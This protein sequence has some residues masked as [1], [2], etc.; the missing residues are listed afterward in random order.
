MSDSYE[1]GSSE[2]RAGKQSFKQI[3]IGEE[4]WIGANSTILGGIEIGNGIGT[5]IASGS[6]VTKSC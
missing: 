6:V 3:K 2:K 5:V 4:V 1:I